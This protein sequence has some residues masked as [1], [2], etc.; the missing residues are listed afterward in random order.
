VSGSV[1]GGGVLGFGGFLTA[2]II[3]SIVIPIINVVL[4]LPI[5]ASFGLIL[6]PIMSVGS[7]FL[8][9]ILTIIM[10]ILRL[11]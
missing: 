5:F 10:L 9:P 2:S 1:I 6:T 4:G 7:I 11:I 8:I 3:G